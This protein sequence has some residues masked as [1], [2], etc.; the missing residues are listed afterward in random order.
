MTALVILVLKSNLINERKNQVYVIW[1]N[2]D[3]LN[4]K[5]TNVFDQINLTFSSQIENNFLGNL[6]S[7]LVFTEIASKSLH[8]SH[9]RL[10]IT[11]QQR[12]AVT[13]QQCA[14]YSYAFYLNINIQISNV[15]NILHRKNNKHF[16]KSSMEKIDCFR[17]QKVYK[18]A[19]F[20]YEKHSKASETDLSAHMSSTSTF[21]VKLLIV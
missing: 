9:K 5:I 10:V 1:H 19:L 20:V 17:S 6:S 3:G 2:E 21:P 4:K 15:S 13:L 11:S 7:F 8:V 14:R 18:K 16:S 12:V